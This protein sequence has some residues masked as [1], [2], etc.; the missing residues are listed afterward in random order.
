MPNF[1]LVDNLCHYFPIR[2]VFPSFPLEYRDPEIMANQLGVFI[3]HDLLTFELLHRESRVCILK[4]ISKP[5]PKAI[6]IGSKWGSLSQQ[7]LIKE[8]STIHRFQHQLGHLNS[9]CHP[10]AI[11]QVSIC[12][13]TYL[14]RTSAYFENKI[15]NTIMTRHS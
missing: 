15:F 6:I 5:I 2:I 7:V 14:I 1:K 4:E 12:E 10:M 3:R 9:L 11:M 13:T 8:D